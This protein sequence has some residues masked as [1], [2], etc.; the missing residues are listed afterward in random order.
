MKTVTSL[1]P[2]D[3]VAELGDPG[4]QTQAR[5]VI[6]TD[7]NEVTDNTTGLIWRRCAEG[8]KI[9]TDGC[10]GNATAF[11]SDQAQSWAKNEAL[12]SGK[13]WRLPS[14]KELSSI[15]DPSRCNPAIDTDAFPGTPGSPFWSAPPVAGE[16]SYAWGV[17]FDYGYV[18]YGSEH[19]SAGY[20]VRLVRSGE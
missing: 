2:A 1:P 10:S 4:A 3:A 14:L 6:S 19:N 9:I 16:P 7:G 15:V 12:T 13:P 18:D 5:Y 11:S 8:M 20:R 17:N